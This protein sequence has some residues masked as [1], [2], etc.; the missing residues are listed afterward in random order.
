MEAI[1]KRHVTLDH[2][3]VGQ[4]IPLGKGVT[5]DV[6]WPPDQTTL[7]SNNS[8]LVLKLTYARRTILFPADIQQPAE[9][10]LLRMPDQLHC[11]VLIAPHHGSFEPTTAAFVTA[12]DPLYIV[13]SNDSTLSQKQRIFERQIGNRPLLRT[14]QCGEIEI[15]IRQDGGL[16][17]TPFV[18][19][20]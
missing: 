13:S 2:I 11:D 10:A 6:L 18:Q 1:H 12:A 7:N 16:T 8:G 9:A 14:N 15:V 20:Q 19:A 4:R 5:I 17:V 3:H